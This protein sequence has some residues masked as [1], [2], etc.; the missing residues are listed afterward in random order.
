MTYGVAQAKPVEIV[1]RDTRHEKLNDVTAVGDCDLGVAIPCCDY[2]IES[3][4]DEWVTG[5]RVADDRLNGGRQSAR[6]A[7]VE[8]YGNWE[9]GILR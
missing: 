4:R 8:T 3:C 9:V 6:V 7:V 2:A 1:L 5:I